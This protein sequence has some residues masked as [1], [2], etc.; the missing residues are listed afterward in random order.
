[1]RLRRKPIA[2]PAAQLASVPDTTHF[3]ADADV[4]AARSAEGQRDR[5]DEPLAQHLE[6][7]AA[8]VPKDARRVALLHE[9]LQRGTASVDELLFAG[10]STTEIAA[11]R[12]LTRAPGESFELHVLT[13]AH[14]PGPE[15][16]LARRVA[17][18]DIDDHLAHQTERRP[19]VGTPPYRWARRHL[20]IALAR[21]AAPVVA[22]HP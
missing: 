1:M 12:L 9:A 20:E 21:T 6:R 8:A 5:H 19:A 10:L 4:L 15:G 18:A 16:D 7:V 3:E 14:A 11:L 13:I 17:V 22:L 2:A